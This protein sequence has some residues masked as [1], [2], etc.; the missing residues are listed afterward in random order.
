M[1]ASGGY[2]DERTDASAAFALRFCADLLAAL[3]LTGVLD[4]R[5]ATT[6]VDDSLNELLSSH[7]QHALKLREI[8][9]AMTVQVELAWTDLQSRLGKKR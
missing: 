3:V 2:M 8:A 1:P 9:A 5:A 4:R 7:P 6:L